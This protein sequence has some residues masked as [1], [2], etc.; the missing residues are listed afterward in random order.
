MKIAIY[1]GAFDPPTIAHQQII[2][3]LKE[4]ADEVWMMPCY[5]HL[6]DKKMSSPEQRIAM[7][8]IVAG[9]EDIVVCDYEF[10]LERSITTYESLRGLSE[11]YPEHD[12]NFVMGGDNLCN[13]P[14]WDKHEQL[15]AEFGIIAFERD[16]YD[17][18]LFDSSKF[19]KLE[20]LPNPCKDLNISSTEVR[21]L[22]FEEY[23][24]NE[25]IL[26]K[27]RKLV[28][29]PILSYLEFNRDYLYTSYEN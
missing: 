21:R 18:T 8:Q 14:K 19:K 13:L 2:K 15:I 10:N 12:F 5:S 20:I 25:N 27:L 28:S 22:Y 24:Y 1:G 3:S 16:G 17:L 6:F 9:I 26:D 4:V 23:G 11:I 7:C 29:E